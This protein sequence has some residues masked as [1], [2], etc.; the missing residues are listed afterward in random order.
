MTLVLMATGGGIVSL[1]IGING[2]DFRTGIA[3]AGYIG[4]VVVV[5][6]SVPTGVIVY[7]IKAGGAIGSTVVVVVVTAA[8]MGGAGVY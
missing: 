3:A 8:G 2:S 7:L 6:T 5:L 4:F 1:V